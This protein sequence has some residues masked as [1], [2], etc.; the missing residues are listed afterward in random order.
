MTEQWRG[1]RS[2]RPAMTWDGVAIAAPLTAFRPDHNKVGFNVPVP[3]S[4]D[5]TQR[6]NMWARL[7]SMGVKVV[8]TDCYWAAIQPTNGG[9]A[10]AGLNDT[11]DATKLGHLDAFFD[12]AETRGIYVWLNVAYTPGWART[13]TTWTIA[14]NYAVNNRVTNSGSNYQC[15]TAHL[16]TVFATDLA[17]GYW[18]L[19]NDDKIPPTRELDVTNLGPDY[20]NFCWL[21]ADRY[22]TSHPNV[23]A[24]MGVWNEPNIST[25]WKQPAGTGTQP[26]VN[27]T[28]DAGM[29]AYLLRGAYAAIKTGVVTHRSTRTAHPEIL[30]TAGCTAPASGLGNGANYLPALF[31]DAFMDA[32]ASSSF[33]HLDHHPYCW[34]YGPAYI[35]DWNAF[36][37]LN[38]LWA[39]LEDHARTDATIWCSEIGAISRPDASLTDATSPSGNG[40]YAAG[41]PGGGWNTDPTAINYTLLAQR[42]TEMF[43]AWRSAT[44]YDD[45][46]GKHQLGPMVWYEAADQTAGISTAWGASAEQDFFGLYEYGATRWVGAAKGGAVDAWITGATQDVT[47]PTGVAVVAPGPSGTCTGICGVVIVATD[48]RDEAVETVEVLI[49]DVIV[50]QATYTPLGYI[51]P[52]DSRSTRDGVH[53][54]GAVATDNAGNSTTSAAITIDVYNPI[55]T[56]VLT[57]LATVIDD[58]PRWVVFARNR[59][60]ERTGIVDYTKLSFIK[61]HNIAG[62]WTLTANDEDV[63]QHLLLPGA[64]I[65]VERN[66]IAV[67]GGIVV[68][69]DRSYAGD[70][71]REIEV[72]GVDDLGQLADRVI[73]PALLTAAAWNTYGVDLR[74]GVASALILGYIDSNAANPPDAARDIYGLT[75]TADP[76][77]GTT[78]RKT[79]RFGNLLET[80]AGLAARSTPELTVKVR[81]VGVQL[82]VTVEAIRD[83]TR[84]QVFS[85]EA[86]TL[87]SW[88]FSAKAPTVNY[89]YVGGGGVGSARIFVE[90]Q[91]SPSI[92]EH[93]RVERYI[94]QRQTSDVEELAKAGTEAFVAGAAKVT[95]ELDLVADLNDWPN[96]TTGDRVT[97]VVD[98]E[99]FVEVV[100]ELEVTLDGTG[101]A[102]HV[103]VG[104]PG[105]TSSK[106][107]AVFRA[108]RQL[109]TRLN[110][111]E[112]I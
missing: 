16:S 73:V 8:R 96:W 31:V 80:I 109:A 81:Q 68:D 48:D 39:V 67:F 54:I 49:D 41:A 106:V 21:I 20:A 37:Q 35:A 6:T 99:A 28:P 53:T 112:T 95:I 34:E 76:G 18:T 79:G 29:Y 83:L 57:T 55:S 82:L 85:V 13:G 104:P 70:G 4:T 92:A 103:V 11:M 77:L 15:V 58:K 102:L 5:T 1:D 74:T 89:A 97:T 7:A 107:P 17:S 98:G 22:A 60:L 56:V 62:T 90:P 19:E 12:D 50:G 43:T 91:D 78:D 9:S 26:S 36:T 46:L 23:L 14:T 47:A 25:F 105:A 69:P 30:V 111:L 93:R 10:A 24:A 72:S 27:Q 59:F 63:A 44:Y 45:A 71:R 52:W 101:E 38:D 64:G 51:Y 87:R 32:G 94:D 40:G 33:D 66:G 100:R 2:Y 110:T 84:S 86:G 75:M 61:R 65:V 108:Q 42:V 88:K 3:D